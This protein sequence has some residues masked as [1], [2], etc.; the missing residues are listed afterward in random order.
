MASA[1]QHGDQP[2][3]ADRRAGG[4]PGHHSGGEHARGQ[5][6][7]GQPAGAQAVAKQTLG[8]GQRHAGAEPSVGQAFG[9]VVVA[10]AGAVGDDQVGRGKPG[11][12]QRLGG[13]G[14]ESAALAIGTGE[15]M[16]VEA[17]APAGQAQAAGVGV[18]HHRAARL[19]QRQPGAVGREGTGPSGIERAQG[20][21][22][23]LPSLHRRR[24]VALRAPQGREAG[25]T[26]FDQGRIARRQRRTRDWRPRQQVVRYVVRLRGAQ[27]Q[28][29]HACGRARLVRRERNPFLPCT[30]CVQRAACLAI[31]PTPTLLWQW[32]RTGILDRN[33]RLTVRGEVV[34]F[35]LGPEGLA[36]AAALE[37]R[38]YPLEDLLFDIA[39][40]FAG[41]R[42]T[43]T[44]PRRIGRLAD[45]CTRAYRR[46]SIDGWLQEGV[47]V[48]Y[49]SGASE[50]VRAIVAEGA[51]TRE[52]LDEVETAGKGDL[53]RLLTEWRSLLRQAAAGAPLVGDG[54]PMNGRDQFI[55]E[56]WDSFRALA[57]EWLREARRDSLPDLP[58]L[59]ADQRRVINHSML[60]NPRPLPPGRTTAVS[61]G[62]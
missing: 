11:P 5:R 60:R 37:D 33:L 48:Q 23:R 47:P 8:G 43:G 4:H 58:P 3:A 14:G 36:L 35:F 50:S 51:R 31:P 57:R 6:D 44:N 41:D 61:V 62:R 1:G 52:V 30:T 45:A 46:I 28:V 20:R 38:R 32:Q 54:A 19:A 22:R 18:E 12:L 7:I 34:S 21:S 27:V 56:R 53:D 26:R 15:V 59:T 40:V 39:N 29:R 24:R 55:A 13:G 17:L 25:A 49:G 9:V 2:G 42:F 16:G 10:G